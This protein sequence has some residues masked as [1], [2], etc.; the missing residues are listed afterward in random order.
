MPILQPGELKELVTILNR[1]C[2]DQAGWTIEP[3]TEDDR[4]AFLSGPEGIQMIITKIWNTPGRLQVCGLFP[5]TP[6]GHSYLPYNQKVPTISVARARGLQAIATA[7]Q[8]RLLP[9]Y[10]PLLQQANERADAHR[11]ALAQQDATVTE[12]AQIPGCTK[13]L[14]PGKVQINWRHLAGDVW[15]QAE[16]MLDGWV[17]L[18]LHR[19]PAPAAHAALVT[20]HRTLT[21]SQCGL[22]RDDSALPSS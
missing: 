5:S 20:L 14:T 2:P 1:L 13:E 9:M 18:K 10:R 4:R 22:V 17:N 6:D 8:R 3:S 15:G 16:V 11:E 19:V 12:L 7:I 21:D